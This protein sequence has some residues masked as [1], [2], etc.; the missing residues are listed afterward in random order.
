MKRILFIV[1]PK[2]GID[3]KKNLP[4]QI[5]HIL[6]KKLFSYDI[7]Y[8]QYRGH[9]IELSMQAAKEGVEII[10][11]IG[12]DG[13]VNEV[14]QGLLGTKSTLAIIPRGS[15]NGLARSLKIPRNTEKAIER[16]NQ[17][18][19]KVIDTG[20]ANNHLF[21]SNA[22]VG[23][24]TLIAKLFADRSQRGLINYSKLVMQ[25]VRTYPSMHYYLTVDGKEMQEQAF[26]VTAANGN[27]F[28]YNFK[29]APNALLDDGLLDVCIMRPLRVRHL[30]PVSLISLSGKLER[31][32]YAKHIRC[33]NLIIKGEE[34]LQ[35]MQVD[36]DAI[37]VKNNRIDINIQPACLKVIV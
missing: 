22:G 29:I 33:R 3:K 26:F 5:N 21:L 27:Q 37:E 20:Y 2:S 31:S 11:A 34:P 24:D 35:W 23:F 15:G 17:L 36:G 32:H 18:K 1:N 30:A 10:T 12:G 25:A 28:G 6:N 4:S 9:A 16:I 7:A 8:T 14:T 13:S 19:T